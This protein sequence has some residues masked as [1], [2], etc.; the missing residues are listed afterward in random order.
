MTDDEKKTEP[1]VETRR[2]TPPPKRG[3]IEPD[4]KG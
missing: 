1:K 3:D 4:K 2:D